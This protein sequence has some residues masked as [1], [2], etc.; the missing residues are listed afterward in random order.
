[1]IKRII[2]IS[3]KAYLSLKDFQLVIKKE[4]VENKIPLEDIW[5]IVIESW[6]VTISQRLL[7][8]IA[9]QEITMLICDEKHLPTWLYHALSWHCQSAKFLENQVNVSSVLKK[10][11]WQKIIQEKILNQAFVLDFFWF[12]WDV[13]RWISKDVRSWDIDNREWYASNIYWKL[14]FWENF[15]RRKENIIN[16]M[17]NYW[18]AIIRASIARWVVSSWLHPSIWIWHSNQFNAFNLVDDL[19]EPFRP[20]VDK[21]IY[22]ILL[23]NDKL[24]LNQEFTPEIK[25]KI[26]EILAQNVVYDK[27]KLPILVAINYYTSSFRD[28]LIDIEK[29]LIPKIFAKI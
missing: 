10:Q 9:N 20:L 13:L 8:E 11:L 24:K 23:N 21:T 6:D 3:N 19:I 15:Q 4:D 22:E 14:L 26:L 2:E 29:F 12:S 25:R 5:V 27:Q 18:Y 28:W 1:M 7:V 16:I 17:L